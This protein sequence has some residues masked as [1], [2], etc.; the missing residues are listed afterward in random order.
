MPTV[1]EPKVN[2]DAKSQPVTPV[3]NEPE[4]FA[5]EVAMEG[6]NSG[7]IPLLL[8]AGLILVVGGTIYYFVKGARDVLTVPVAS[9]S[10]TSILNAQ[11]PA[12]IRFSTG[13]V[14]SNVNE[15]SMDPHYKLLAKTGV[16]VTK[17]KGYSSLIVALTPAGEKLFSTIKGVE[18][19]SNP[20][21]TVTYVVPLAERKLVEVANVNM[22][23]PHL[24]RVE[25]SWKWEP[26]R[27]GIEFDASG[28][29][30]KSFSSWDRATLIKSYGADFYGAPATKSSIVLMES[31]NGVW[32][33]Y[34]E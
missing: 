9:S 11:G 16:I 27:L 5:A 21:G 7:F 2:E 4:L 3:Y 6:K 18:K 15:K 10:V 13:T 31:D 32:K 24:A 1:I 33:P 23:K 20:D 29:L 28:A 8:I 22:I 34:V 12:T 14:V 19:A 30:V 17:P 25:Y 26:N